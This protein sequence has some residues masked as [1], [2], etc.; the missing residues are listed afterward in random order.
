MLEM[1]LVIAVGAAALGIIIAA[2]EEGEFPGWGRMCVCVLAT[3]VASA[4]AG[5]LSPV[6]PLVVGPA[7]GAVV[8]GVVISATCGMS[9]R[10]ASI[11]AG[12]Y[13]AIQIA[14]GWGVYLL[15]R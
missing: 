13:L 4:V 7:V 5:A 9:V 2:M 14:L 12:I 15:M 6:A 3:S 11:A 1:I 8:G 10:R